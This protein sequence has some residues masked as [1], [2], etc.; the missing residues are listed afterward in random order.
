MPV[1]NETQPLTAADRSELL[2]RIQSAV[3]TAEPE[4]G[5]D[6]Q[7]AGP[8]SV[9]KL[10]P[11]LEDM[12][13]ITRRS[14]ADRIEPYLA[15][16]M[17][18]ICGRCPAQES[19]G[20]CPLRESGGC[21]LFSNRRLVIEVIDRFMAERCRSADV[22][23]ALQKQD[24]DYQARKERHM[25]SRILIAVDDTAPAAVAVNAG[26]E[27]AAKL[28]AELALV[29]VM[30]PP[31]P[32]AMIEGAVYDAEPLDEREQRARELLAKIRQ[33]LPVSLQVESMTT[34]GY[35]ANQIVEAAREWNADLII[36]G[37]HGRHGVSRFILGSTAEAV[38]R[39]AHCAVLVARETS[40]ASSKENQPAEAYAVPQ[41]V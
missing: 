3:Q 2:G 23:V 39:R 8:I 22:P 29:H 18:D 21:I 36:V 34:E 11:H 38:M 10:S 26:V 24:V 20:F 1:R 14:S 33:T 25:L 31:I 4:V 28:G 6:A 17:E 16:M 40:Q 5:A 35:P 27:L 15:Q 32:I 9:E 19:S 37:T 12:I 41:A 30:Q 13:H 7:Q